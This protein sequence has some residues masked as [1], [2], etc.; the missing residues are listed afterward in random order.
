MNER[1]FLCIYHAPCID[2]FGAAYAMWLA[3]PDTEFHPAKH[4]DSPPDVTGRDVY[5]LDFSYPAAVMQEMAE[6][7]ASLWVLD[8]HLTAQADLE[9]LLEAGILEGEF[10][11]TRSG[12]GMAWDHFLPGH[13]RPALID[14][15]EDR[16]L[17]QFTYGASTREFHA[18]VSSHPYDFDTWDELR[19]ALD[20]RPDDTLAEGRAILRKFNKDLDELLQVT[21][22]EI[23]IDGM[24]V[25]AANL[26]YIYASEAGHRL[27]QGLNTFA[28]VYYDEPD[29][30]YVSLRSDRD[31]GMDVSAIAKKFGGGG[32][33]NA[34]G[35][36]IYH[37]HVFPDGSLRDPETITLLG[38]LPKKEG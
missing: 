24:S 28:A 27:C 18:L 11:L 16:D 29:Q 2:G 23:M 19:A 20:I 34:A 22:R 33:K 1:P 6:D 30:R 26:P 32:H 8:H 36:R 9:P 21:T 7:A 35:F 10:D 38:N 15:I 3:H 31:V 17:W 13:G 37:E 5:I 14:L 12:A 25:P 4:G